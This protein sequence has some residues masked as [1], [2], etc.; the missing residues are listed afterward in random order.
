VN[1]KATSLNPFASN[2]LIILPTKPLWTPSGLTIRKVRSLVAAIVFEN[3]EKNDNTVQRTI[4]RGR[5]RLQRRQT[6]HQLLS[7][8]HGYEFRCLLTTERYEI[9]NTLAPILH[10]LWLE[11]PHIHGS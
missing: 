10:N 3:K 6:G 9:S 1:F 2:L 4:Q 8:K 7:Q 11:V 5:R